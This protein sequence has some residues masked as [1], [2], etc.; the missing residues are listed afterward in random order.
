[1]NTPKKVYSNLLLR[2]FVKDVLDKN[3]ILPQIL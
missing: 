3:K 2:I 1:M